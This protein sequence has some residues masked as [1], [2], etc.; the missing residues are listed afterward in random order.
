MGVNR[1]LV[2][3]FVRSN[4]FE[5]VGIFVDVLEKIRNR[6]RSGMVFVLTVQKV[7]FGACCV[8]FIRVFISFVDGTTGLL[9]FVVG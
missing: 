8:G 6:R 1:L 3:V 9:Q 4:V 2:G 5:K 7:L